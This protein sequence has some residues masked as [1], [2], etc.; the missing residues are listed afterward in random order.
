[1][2]LWTKKQMILLLLINSFKN[3]SVLE[4]LGCMKLIH[5]SEMQNDAF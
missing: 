1:M 2:I 4:P 5:T 3:F